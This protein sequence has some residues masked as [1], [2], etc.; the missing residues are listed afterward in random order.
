MSVLNFKGNKI[1]PCW[2]HQS[3]TP[4]SNNTTPPGVIVGAQIQY[5]YSINPLKK[6]TTF[7]GRK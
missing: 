2:I 3:V 6:F 7:K 4:S 1:T 5:V